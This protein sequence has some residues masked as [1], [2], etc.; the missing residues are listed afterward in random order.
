MKKLLPV[1]GGFAAGGWAHLFV[2]AVERFARP[3]RCGRRSG[4][5]DLF[6]DSECVDLRD[7]FLTY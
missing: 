3:A 5:P 7:R 4:A 6:D 2:I 1:L